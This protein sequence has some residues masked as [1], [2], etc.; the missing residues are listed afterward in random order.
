MRVVGEGMWELYFQLRFAVN[1]K[2]QLKKKK[3]L[4]RQKKRKAQ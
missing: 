4:L 1:L 2:L 3:G